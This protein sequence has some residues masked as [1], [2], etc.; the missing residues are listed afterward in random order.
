MADHEKAALYLIDGDGS[1][2]LMLDK[3]TCSNGIVW[4]ADKKT[5][6]YVDTPTLTVMAFDY[7]NAT[8]RIDNGRI[9]VKVPPGMGAPDGM[10]IDAEGKLWVAMWSGGC[11]NSGD[12]ETGKLWIK[13]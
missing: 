1:I 3:V 2:H 8:G 5:M 6:Y 10:N 4:S 9:V 13:I 11:V 12:L 7:D